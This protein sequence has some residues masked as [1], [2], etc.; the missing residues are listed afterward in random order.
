M[1]QRYAYS[2][3]E[4]ERMLPVGDK[5]LGVAGAVR[6]GRDDFDRDRARVLHSAALRRL[7]DKTQ[8]V[9]PGSGDTPRTRLTHSLEVAQIARGIGKTLGADPDLTE[10]AGLSHDIGHPPYGHNGER[11]LDEAARKC[12]GFEGNAQT[13][14]ILSRLEPK[15]VDSRGRSYGLNLTRAS[16]DAACKYPWGPVDEEGNKRLKYSAYSDDLDVL[17]W[18]RAGAPAGKKCLEAQIMDWADDVAYSVHD[19]E[20]GILSGRITLSVLWD[21]VELA[22]LAEKGAR[23]FGGQPEDLLDAADRLRRMDLVSRAADFTG[24]LQGLTGLKAM[25][26]ELVSRFVTACVTGTREKFGEQPLAR[27]SADLVIPP[28]VQAEVTLLKSV[29]VLYV[30]DEHSHM[31]EQERQRD[32]IFRV[33]EYLW[34]GGE[35]ALDPLYRGWFAQATDDAAKLRVVID[36]VA[37]LTENR[38]E[39]MDRTASGMSAAWA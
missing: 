23:V 30:M 3:H 18:A 21:L 38:L 2:A 16:I 25:T 27:Y 13:L 29:A 19:V 11:A 34:Q 5:S 8:V 37:S 31:A 35:G 14:R 12:G 22:Q 1:V 6:D 28:Q 10:L 39:R 20:D 15:A 33:T 24:D 7:A 36:Q 4:L 17:E 26:S 9:G 32:R